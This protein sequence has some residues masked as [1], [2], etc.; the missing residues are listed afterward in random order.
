MLSL[1]PISP[2]DREFLYRVYASTRTEELA[3]TDWNDAQK[4]AFLRMQFN[5]QDAYYTQHYPGARFQVIEQD[6][7]PVGRLYIDQWPG[8]VRIVDITLLPEWRN[9]GLGSRLLRDIIGQA[10]RAGLPLTIHVE[11]YNP[12]LRLYQRLGFE[13]AGKHGVYYL[14]RRNPPAGGASP[15]SDSPTP[16]QP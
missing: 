10:E 13:P 5:A 16:K 7:Q 4:E 2:D 12:A 15:A 3:L 1:R 11:M 9:H 8:E 6:G 14:M